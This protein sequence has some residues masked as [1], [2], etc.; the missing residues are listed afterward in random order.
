MLSSSHYLLP[1]NSDTLPPPTIQL[2]P[3]L[4]AYLAFPL[5]NTSWASLY[6]PN[7]ILLFLMSRDFPYSSNRWDSSSNPSHT[8]PP[9]TNSSWNLNFPYSSSHATDTHSH[10]PI[11]STSFTHFKGLPHTLCFHTA[12]LHHI[13]PHAEI[14][15]TIYYS[16]CHP[17]HWQIHI[18]L[19]AHSPLSSLTSH[20]Q[21]E[22]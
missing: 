3:S 9:F 16:T 14:Q 2:T 7:F 12:L 22:S 13:L 8:L 5:T 6:L 21:T 19:Q 1:P 15:T 11:Y 20:N 10:R 4:G 18:I 17:H